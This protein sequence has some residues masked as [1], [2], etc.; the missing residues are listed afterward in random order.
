[1]KTLLK[2]TLFRL[3][4]NDKEVQSGI[5]NHFVGQEV[6]AEVIE[7]D[8]VTGQLIAQVGNERALIAQEDISIYQ[9][10][11]TDEEIH[12]LIGTT[13]NCIVIGHNKKNDILLSRSELMQKRIERYCK[14]ETVDATIVS[15]AN[16]ALYL[17]FDEGL[18]GKMYCN[19]ITSSK[20]NKPSDLYN[21][22]DK[23]K[24][25]I[26]K[27]Q[28]DGRFLLSRISLY[29]MN[30]LNIECGNILRCKI[31][32]RVKEEPGYFVEVEDNPNYSGIFDINKYNYFNNYNV[33]DTIDLRVVGIKENRQLR[34]KTNLT[35]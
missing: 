28:D 23:I 31:T 13:I 12:R 17:E 3:L 24:C 2:S 9:T 29:K 33:G 20:V 10:K 16:N 14:D 4:T 18:V 7:Y 25:N 8:Y 11:D 30:V 5:N 1:M 19:Q 35:R 22:G 26:L 34:F 15:T 32:Q 6:Q 21:I 27:K